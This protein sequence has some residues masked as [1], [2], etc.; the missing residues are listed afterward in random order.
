MLYRVDCKCYHH[1][2]KRL[3]WEVTDVLAKYTRISH[4]M[5]HTCIESSC[6]YTLSLH[7]T[8]FQLYLNETKINKRLIKAPLWTEI[9]QELCLS[10]RVWRKNRQTYDGVLFCYNCPNDY[11]D[12]SNTSRIKNTNN[13][14]LKFLFSKQNW[15]FD[16][17]N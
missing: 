15:I 17:Q 6:L 3:L 2:P 11:K 5:I 8:V 4:F 14:S 7:D 12:E 16:D 10:Y 9:S 13:R 1:K